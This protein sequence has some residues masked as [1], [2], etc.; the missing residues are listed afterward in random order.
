VLECARN[1]LSMRTFGF[2]FVFDFPRP[3]AEG[4]G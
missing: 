1:G 2:S 4:L 3:L